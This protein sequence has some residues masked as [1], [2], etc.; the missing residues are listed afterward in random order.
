MVGIFAP[1]I[2]ALP[3]FKPAIE[4][5]PQLIAHD[6]GARL[7]YS[8]RMSLK[9]AGYSP[10]ALPV[11]GSTVISRATAF[12]LTVKFPVSIAG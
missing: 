1:V 5:F 7:R 9:P 2:T 11:L 12:V 3:P 10:L 6:Q 8:D 4:T